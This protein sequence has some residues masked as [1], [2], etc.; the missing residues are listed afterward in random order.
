M[1]KKCIIIKLLQTHIIKT[2]WNIVK[3][4]THTRHKDEIPPLNVDGSVVEDHQNI[5]NI[6]STYFTT[7]TDKMGAN[8]LVHINVSSNN[9]DPLSYLYQ[10]FTSQFP[11]IKLTPVTLKEIREIIKSLRWKNSHGYDDISM[12]ILKISLPFIE[13]PLTYICNRMLTTGIFPT[14]LKYS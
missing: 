5:V 12:K 1:P 2:M 13:S 3:T 14:R 4:E 10:V 11:R 7:V 6:F 8:N 9:A